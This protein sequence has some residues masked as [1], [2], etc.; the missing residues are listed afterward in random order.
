MSSSLCRRLQVF[1][2]NCSQ[3]DIDEFTKPC[4]NKT[5]LNAPDFV[6]VG[7]SNFGYFIFICLLVILC[8]IQGTL[9]YAKKRK[10]CRK[11]GVV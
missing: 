11:N 4:N 9:C 7:D 8:L 5:R 3:A 6:Y 1:H 10:L 2:G